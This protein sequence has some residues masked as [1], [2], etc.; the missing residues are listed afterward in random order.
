MKQVLTATVAAMGLATVGLTSAVAND[1]T[2][3]ADA[4]AAAAVP[5]PARPE[6]LFVPT[7]PCR[8]ADT[9]LGGG[10]I[11]SGSVRNFYVRGTAGFPAQGGRSGGCGVPATATSVAT[12][13]TVAGATGLGYMIGYP[14]GTAAPVANFVSYHANETTTVNPT[15]ALAAEGV[16]PHLAIKNQGSPAHLLLDITGYYLPQIQ[17]MV[18]YGG[19]II[20]AGST[21]MLSAVHNGTGDYTVTVDGDVSYCSPT[22]VPYGNYSYTRAFIYSTNQVA[23]LRWGLSSGS[24]THVDSHFYLTVA[25]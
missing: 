17:G 21:R 8:V 24:V 5:R 15:F 19:T 25:C 16:N 23:G 7:T 6:L 14:D 20:S 9:R 1:V 2:A 22:A 4:G 11:P 18:D 13:V 12:N 3:P 10:K